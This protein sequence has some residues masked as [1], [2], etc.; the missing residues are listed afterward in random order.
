MTIMTM[1]ARTTRWRRQNDEDNDSADTIV[2]N[3]A[4]GVVNLY[5]RN[6]VIRKYR[7]SKYRNLE[8]PYF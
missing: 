8:I 5:I 1:S 3:V 6:I 7:I 4:I 2:D